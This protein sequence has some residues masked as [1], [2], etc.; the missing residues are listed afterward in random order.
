MKL[1]KIFAIFIALTMVLAVFCACGD[2]NNGD[3]GNNNQVENQQPE[4]LPEEN[5]DNSDNENQPASENETPAQLET[6]T[7]KIASPKG[8]TTMGMVKLMSDSDAGNTDLKYDVQIFGTADE[9]VGLLTKGEIDAANIPCNLA[10]VLYNKTEGGFSAIGINTLGVLYVLSASENAE[11]SLFEISDLA[12]KTVYSTGK[13]TTPEYVLNYILKSNGLD[14]TADVNIEYLSEA[15]EVAAKMSETDDAI[16]VLPQ[17]YVTV[18][19]TQNDKLKIVFDLTEEWEKIDGT[20]LVTG[21]TV[22]RNEFLEANPN[23]VKKFMEDYAA[24]VEYVN[25]NTDEAAALVGGYDIVAEGVA[26]KALPYCNIVFQTGDELKANAGAYLNVLFESDPSSVGG[27]LPDD[28][29]Y[30]NAK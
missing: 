13:G 4:N 22:V 9:I 21:V 24:S 2:T 28:G 23:A 26:K 15:T 30:Y 10:S 1:K 16:A 7:V 19:M 12:G 8:P 29:F 11:E 25:S 5:S 27:A 14:P 18:A 3:S 20:Q 6:D 17:P